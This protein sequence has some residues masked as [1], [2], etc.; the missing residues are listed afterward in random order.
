MFKL[1]KLLLVLTVVA[2]AGVM[3]LP[4]GSVEYTDPNLTAPLTVP[5]FSMFEGE[6]GAYQASFQ[7]VRSS[8]AL[9]QEMEKILAEHYIAHECP[10]G[11][12]VYFDQKNYITIYGYIIE[13]GFP[14]SKYAIEYGRGNSCN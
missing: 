8:W 2:V 13:Q 10:D 1:I 11:K 12:K 9:E 5:S 4:L 6:T 7:S 3:F 14:F